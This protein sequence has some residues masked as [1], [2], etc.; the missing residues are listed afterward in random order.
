[1]ICVEVDDG[2]GGRGSK[3]EDEGVEP[4]VMMRCMGCMMMRENSVLFKHG[5]ERGG[6]EGDVIGGSSLS[7]EGGMLWGGCVAK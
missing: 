5:N 6:E 3:G 2:K 1:M 4:T 7:A